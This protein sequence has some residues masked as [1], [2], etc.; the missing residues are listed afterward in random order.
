MSR[1]TIPA[2]TWARTMAV[3][4]V[5]MVLAE[6]GTATAAELAFTRQT[7]RAGAHGVEV[8]AERVRWQSG[9]SALIVCDF[10]DSHNC[11]S[12]VKRVNAMAPRVAEVVAAARAA[13]V[14]IIH[15][16]SDCMATYDGHPARRR[17]QEA[18][19]AAQMPD[20]IADWQHW[21]S[22][23]EEKA[24][25][26]I[27]ATDGGCDDSP[28]EQAAWETQLVADGRRANG[29]RWP[30]RAQHPA[31][32][33]DP[34]RDAISDR[35]E[36]IWNL[37]E[38]RGIKN[39]M[40]IGVH[41][42]MCVCGRSFGL[43]QM[44]RLGKNALLL[45]DLT[46]AMYNPAQPPHVS[47]HRGTELTVA[48]IE[49]W[50]APTA[51]SNEVFGGKAFAFADDP[52][53]VVAVMLGEDEYKTWESVPAYTE[54]ELG[55]HYRLRY[56]RE[57]RDAPGDFAGTEALTDARVLLLSVRRRALPEAQLRAVRD[58][59]ARGGGIVAIRTSSHAFALRAGTAVPAGHAVW[60]EWDAEVLGG[61]Y[62]QHHGNEVPTTA[63]VMAGVDHPVLDGV[64]RESFPT[65]SGL[66]INTPLRP[67]AT[68]LL[69][70]RARGIERPEPVA[71][72]HR[73]AVG[74]RVFYTSLGHVDDF[75]RAE[76]RRLIA[77]AVAWAGARED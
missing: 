24:G 48:H 35:G 69:V 40:V 12:A 54:A 67:G 16:P 32:A 45:R 75:D 53:P 42:N 19:R 22:P 70:G 61:N 63:E 14:M 41:A 68:P 72:V 13:G 30:W 33:I 47:H 59:V 28:E 50:I 62:Q 76:F 26:P 73:T 74:G 20:G 9:E 71:W 66:Y 60:P 55:K 2:F 49:R 23:E 38:A 1:M 21:I 15:A 8:V 65:G 7:R 4:A 25:Y 11:G 5:A 3:L 46:D 18:P 56:V 58:F 36:E 37:L 64:S 51:L 44:A 31:V 6:G 57:V 17:A 43:R 27:D 39:V 10:W 77:N 34:G 52:R 29:A